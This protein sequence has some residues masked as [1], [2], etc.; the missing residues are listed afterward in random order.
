V[1]EAFEKVLKTCVQVDKSSWKKLLFHFA[2]LLEEERM[3]EII[4]GD[5][6]KFRGLLDIPE[7]RGSYSVSV[8]RGL[9]IRRAEH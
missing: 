9:K 4:R 5:F 6:T 3:D 1:L 8:G 7:V 2:E